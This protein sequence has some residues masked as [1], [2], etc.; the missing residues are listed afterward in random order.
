MAKKKSRPSKD[1]GQPDQSKTSPA[2]RN[3]RGGEPVPEAGPTP[4]PYII[5]N[6]DI[7]E[8]ELG[9]E[10]DNSVPT[11]GY[12]MLPMVGLGGSAGSI[13]ALQSFFSTMPADS[14]MAFVVILHLSPDHESNLAALLQHTTQMKVIQVQETE[15]VRPNHVYVIPPGKALASLDG[16]LRLTDLPSSRGRRVTVDLFFRTLADTHG[17]QSIAVVLSG[18]AADG[19][20]GIKRIKERGGLT[21]AQD[22]QQA[23]HGSMPR[24]AISTGMVDWVLEVDQMPG[25]LLEY[26]ER[27]RRI[28]IPPEEGPHPVEKIRPSLDEA[29]TALRDVLIFLKTRSGHEF[30]YYKRATILRRISRRLQVNG[31]DDLP[32]YLT[33]LRTHTGE[34]GALLQDLLISVTNFFRDR[35]AFLSLET[36]I[37]KLFRGKG[38]NDSVRV[39]VTAC[40]TGEE[41]YS[42]AILLREYART[43]EA[44]PIIQVFATDLDEAAVQEAREAIYPET[45]AADVSEERLRHFFVKEHRGYRLRREI[46]EI[47]LFAQHDLLGDS[48]FSRLDLVTCRNLLIYLNREAQRRVLDIFHFSLRCGGL[49]FLG[50]SE[51]VDEETALFSNIDKKH[52][53]YAHRSTPRTTLPIPSG[54][55]TIARARDAQERASDGAGASRRA[56]EANTFK[57]GTQAIPVESPKELPG[58]WADLHFRLIDRIAPP[59]ILVDS[60]HEMVH[61]SKT[62]G[63]L[64]NISGGEPTRNL[65]RLVHP[66]LRIELRSALYRAAQTQA[67]AEVAATPIEI[68]GHLFNVT[69]RVVSADDVAAGHF[70]VLFE[71]RPVE[72]GAAEASRSSDPQESVARQLE[73]ELERLKSLLRETVE[74]YEAS[75]EEF[76]ASNEE[77]QAMNE[78][79]RSATEELE[80]S[81]EEL[82]STNEELTTVNE[83]LKTKVD[84]LARANSDMQN[85]MSATAIATVFLDRDLRIMRFTP[86]AVD[87]FNFIL[88]DVGRPLSDVTHRLDYPSMRDDAQRV[89]QTLIANEC[90]VTN[91]EGRCFLARILPY[92]TTEDHIAGVV[93]TFVDITARRAAESRAMKSEEHVRQS[94]ATFEGRVRERTRELQENELALKDSIQTWGERADSLQALAHQLTQAERLE[95]KRLAHVLHDHVQQ[96]LVAGKIKA[97]LTRSEVTDK[98]LQQRLT[99]VSAIFDDAIN[100]TRSLVVDLVPPLLHDEGLPAALGWLATRMEAQHGL[101]VDL[102]VDP[103]VNLEAEEERDFLFQAAR[104]LL[105]NVVKHSGTTNAEVRLARVDSSVELE[106]ADDGSGFDRSRPRQGERSFGLFQIRQRIEALG[107]T[108]EVSSEEGRG[109]RIK[110]V[111]PG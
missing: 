64:L 54:P 103:L 75:G 71:T 57:V 65:L 50:S 43:L 111:V 72:E 36:H 11:R 7:V 68:E 55:S 18:A 70:L 45:I 47:V 94:T 102:D 86:P 35:E 33:F 59:S 89:L 90:E 61:V 77:L 53:I 1:P 24:A 22:P 21:I 105:L 74:Q 109:T 79:L 83:E 44:P 107:G 76:K 8:Q 42:V 78:E 32:G 69:I 52:R 80:T 62:A 82:Q 95:R 38:A 23:E 5:S 34:S 56:L 19:A 73:H 108:V 51:T 91:S 30:S 49:L 17:P 37:P 48:P 25:R 60:E 40:A 27:S 29:E 67:S 58:S 28:R 96:I 16:H 85:L 26:Q 15:K 9:D 98:T 4:Q 14:G 12:Q 87:L 3:K 97:D 46:R 100:L 2:K 88:T 81:R 39:W 104:E 106:V 84:E 20:I 92:R 13:A 99:E 110:C 63:R 6:P 66:M 93:V 31:V 101:S 41:A 10:I